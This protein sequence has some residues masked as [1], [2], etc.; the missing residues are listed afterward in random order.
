MGL[1]KQSDKEK[2][3]P[4]RRLPPGA[5]QNVHRVHIRVVDVDSIYL[6]IEAGSL[7]CG[8]KRVSG[9]PK[10]G[11]LAPLDLEGYV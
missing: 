3:G 1:K 2:G 5:D 6:R 8:H 11:F 4:T 7:E 10:S 9:G